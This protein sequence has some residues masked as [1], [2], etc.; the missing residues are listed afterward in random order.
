[1]HRDT[2]NRRQLKVLK[3]KPALWK[4]DS[5]HSL[6]CKEMLNESQQVRF[7]VG[8]DLCTWQRSWGLQGKAS[9]LY[10]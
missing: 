8:I 10:S 6:A 3:H 7:V 5:Q 9:P 1:M 4:M 2:T